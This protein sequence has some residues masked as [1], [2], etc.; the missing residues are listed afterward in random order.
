MTEDSA[1]RSRAARGILPRP[2][3]LALLGYLPTLVAAALFWFSLPSPLF[4]PEYSTILLDRDGR[5][6]SAAIAAD[7]Q[8]RFPG[9]GEIPERFATALLAREDKRFFRHPGVDPLAMARALAA[10]ARAGEVV[11]GGSTITMQVI[12]LSRPGK[13]RTIPEKLLEAIL[14]LRLEMSTT[15][16]GI[17]RLFASNAPFGGN[18]VG[19]EAASWRYFG[20]E[21]RTLSWAE[22]ALLAVLPNSP[23][24]IH[25]GRNREELLARRDRLLAALHRDGAID[26]DALRLSVGEPLPPAPFPLPRDAPHLLVTLREGLD[27]GAR[28]ATSLDRGLQLRVN[29]IL[30]RRLELWRQSGI[31]NAAVLVLDVETGDPLAYA[32]NVPEEGPGS[33]VDIIKSVRSTGSLL[34][35]FLYALMLDAGELLPEQL[36]ADIPT[37]IGGFQPENSAKTYA[38]AVP[39]NV[40]LAHSLNVPAVRLLRTFGLDRFADALRGLGLSSLNRPASSYGLTLILGGAEGSLWDLTHMY[41]GLAR[42]ARGAAGFA[43]GSGACWLTLSA[44][45]EVERPGEEGAWR[46]YLGS[47]R[48]AWKTGTSYGFR[49]AWAIGVTP[50]YAVGVWVGNASG[51]G[52]PDI[53]GSSAAAPV[54]FD[55]FGLLGDSGWFAVPEAD[56]VR[57]TVCARSGLK[58]G[59]YCERTKE[60]LAPPAARSA[61]TCG[62]CRLVHLDP[63]GRYRATTCTQPM[64]S[65]KAVSWFVLPPAMEWYYA[66][67]HSDYRPLPPFRPGTG[68]R[69]ADRSTPSLSLLFPEQGGKIYVPIDLDG[70]PGRTVFHAAHRS[71][72]ATIFWHM[73]GQYIGETTELHDR[74]ARPGPGTHTLTLVDETGEELVRTFT[75]LSEK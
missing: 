1:G 14:A 58:A 49:D 45:L 9:D 28:I 62:Y 63:T 74:E 19:F 70:R 56:L 22:C 34:K 44:L 8:W 71:P 5:L 10:N 42:R 53:K 38:G 43:L 26:E 75:C 4:S 64:G 59:L 11:S 55:V 18:V 66:R 54:L 29:D 36:V 69:E 24:L 17:L 20:R 73:D 15:K 39:A 7:G 37:R 67:S 6:L 12:R 52:R 2:L 51:E 3:L 40:A 13:P 48:I 57:V 65:L 47:K 46:D 61:D 27:A 68:E 41:A 33:A 32:G 31:A 23:G 16:A 25:P 30:L 72:R 35:P 21:P 60:I 50:R